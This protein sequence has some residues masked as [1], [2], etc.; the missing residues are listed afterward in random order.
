M[1][2]IVSIDTVYHT[3]ITKLKAH[4]TL[5]RSEERQDEDCCGNWPTAN[6][7][8]VALIRNSNSGDYSDGGLNPSHTT[9]TIT[10]ITT[11]IILV[12][13]SAAEA[14][15][16]ITHLQLIARLFRYNLE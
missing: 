15:Y 1:R 9:T 7:A 12:S 13:L 14:L 11:I 5:C 3:G 10:S 16:F 4:N 6:N 2:H 8:T